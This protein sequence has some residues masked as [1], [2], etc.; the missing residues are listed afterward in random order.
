[1]L[2]GMEWADGLT[3][4]ESQ[5]EEGLEDEDLRPMHFAVDNNT[6][7]KKWKE[8]DI[9]LWCS[10]DAEGRRDATE[11]G[12]AD[13]NE[14]MKEYIMTSLPSAARQLAARGTLVC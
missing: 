6:H 4:A 11:N 12:K 2:T 5:K 13:M 14:W 10:Y 1:M 9:K 8:N 3:C 7:L